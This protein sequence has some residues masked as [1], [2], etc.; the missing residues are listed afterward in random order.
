MNPVADNH[1]VLVGIGVSSR[2]EDD[3]RKALEPL[4]LMLEAVRAAGLDASG[5]ELSESRSQALPGVS[6]P[7]AASPVLRAI[8][9]QA[10]E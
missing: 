2:R 9:P 5:V 6:M 3:W 4:D 7:A 8:S 10:F 1:P